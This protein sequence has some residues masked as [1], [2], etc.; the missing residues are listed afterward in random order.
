M[1]FENTRVWFITGTSSGLGK[2]FVE[3]V[4][5][6]GERVVATLRKPEVLAYLK[7]KYTTEQLLVLQLDVVNDDQIEA[8]FTATKEH[9][10][11][12]D[13]VVN[14]AGYG[15]FGEAEGIPLDEAREQVEVLFWAP[16]K[17]S[18]KAVKFFREN[19]PADKSRYIFNVSTAGGYNGVPCLAFYSAGKFALE[20]F[21]ESL[22]KE[23]PPSW[24]IKACIIEPGGFDTRW[25]GDLHHHPQPAA[26]LGPDTPT[27]QWRALRKNSGIA[28]TGNPG[29]AATVLIK[30]SH[31]PVNELPTR[32]QFGTDAW[33]I[34]KAKAEATARDAEKWSE[35][36]HSTNNDGVDKEAIIRFVAPLVC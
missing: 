15:L 20:G 11:R 17:I 12:L 21:T 35:V 22:N 28:A 27:S 36:S 7:E 32:I 10:G 16:V 1:T 4:L 29:K 25:S 3:A 24:G 31:I 13:V 23:F 6:S 2:C 33:A 30:L 26:Y 5:A 8:A 18:L 14:N 34:V 9:F 19:G